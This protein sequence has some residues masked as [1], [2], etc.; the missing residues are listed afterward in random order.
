VQAGRYAAML[1]P[2]LPVSGP[3]SPGGLCS[4]GQG[5]ATSPAANIVL[6]SASARTVRLRETTAAVGQ[7][8]LVWVELDAQGDENALGFSLQFDASRLRFLSASLG[9]GATSASLMVN[10]NQLGTGNIGV[11]MALSAGRTFIVGTQTLLEARFVILTPSSDTTALVGFSDMPIAREVVSVEAR[12]LPATF[13]NAADSSGNTPVIVLSVPGFVDQSCQ[14]KI[15]GEIGRS[16]IIEASTDFATWVPVAT[17]TNTDGILRFTD[18]E[19]SLH[20]YRFYRAKLNVD[21][22]GSNR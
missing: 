11:A 19:R 21:T 12:S 1:D 13:A 3:T 5:S 15:A 8:N 9:S 10:T 14:V 6:Q 7:T 16:Y 18:L 2:W 22:A 17:V 4:V 20:W